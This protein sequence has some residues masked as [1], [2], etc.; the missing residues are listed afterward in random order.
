MGAFLFRLVHEE[1]VRR[2]IVEISRAYIGKIAYK[3]YAS[4]GELQNPGQGLNCYGFI[5]FVLAEAG[6][7]VPVGCY[8]LY[9]SLPHVEDPKIADLGFTMSRKRNR[10]NHV[11]LFSGNS[12][13]HCAKQ[14]GCVAETPIGL[15]RPDSYRSI[16]PYL[17]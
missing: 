7:A 4:P 10:P 9:G 8:E 5:R 1:P 12:V 17:F 2:R 13:I 6:I 14:Y 16:A 11:M 3:A 15:V